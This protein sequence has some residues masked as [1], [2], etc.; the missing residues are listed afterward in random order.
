MVKSYILQERDGSMLY[1]DA[2]IVDSPEALKIVDHP[3]RMQ[4]L[5][6][7][8]KKPMYPAELAKEMKMHEQKIYYHIKQ[9]M[10]SGIL[11][12]VGREEIRGTVAKKLSPK[13]LNFALTMSKEWK[14]LASLIKKKDD[15]TLNFLK[16]FIQNNRLNA[17][18]VVG[19]PD[20]HGPHKAR[21][22][23]GHYAIDLGL[24]LGGLCSMD[25]NFSTKLDVDIDLKESR[26]LILVGGPV[27]NHVVSKINDFL[28]AKF[29]DKKPWGIITKKATY[30]E[31][32]IGMISRLPNPYN[33]EYFV[34]VLSGIRFIGTKA[35]VFAFTRNTGQVIHR[36]TGQKEFHAIVQGF[37]LDGDG[38]IDSVEILE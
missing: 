10:N 22:R 11:D 35:A 21:A 29:S 34:L 8:A 26:N 31:E 32:S 16:P 17:S 12:V 18:I 24:F 33:P 4:I 1:S 28:P 2:L 20:P 38:K 6:L 7:L 36:F 9:M 27:T 13:Q 30:T 25:E 5:E 19:S 37:D 14:P 3:I 15:T 23:D